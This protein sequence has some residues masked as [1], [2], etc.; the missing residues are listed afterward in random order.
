MATFILYWLPIK[1]FF[2]IAIPTEKVSACNAATHDCL[3]QSHC[4]KIAD[5]LFQIETHDTL[6]FRVP[7]FQNRKIYNILFSFCAK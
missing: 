4:E 1:Y 7:Q 6:Q 3:P 2:L 5:V